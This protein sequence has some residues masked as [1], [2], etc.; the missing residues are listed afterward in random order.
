MTCQLAVI[1]GGTG[2]FAA[3]W[4]ALRKG[5]K[6]TVTEEYDRLGGQLTSQAVPPDEHPWIESCGGTASYRQFRQYVRRYYR[7]WYPLTEEAAARW[8]RLNPGEGCVSAL[9]HEPAVSSAVI[10]ALLRPYISSGQL[11]VL[12]N[13]VPVQV[14]RQGDSIKSVAVKRYSRPAYGPRPLGDKDFRLYTIEAPF[15]IDATETGD[16]LPLAGLEYSIGAESKAQTGEPHAP[17]KADPLNQQAVSWCFVIDY[18]PDRQSVIPKPAQYGFWRGYIPDLKPAWG[19]PL[20]SWQATHPITLEPVVRSFNPLHPKPER[21]PM[22]LW[23]FRRISCAANFKYPSGTSDIVLVNWPQIDY[24]LGQVI[25]VSEEEK[26]RHLEGARQLSLSMLYWM[27]TEAPREDGQKGWPGLGLRPDITQT[28]DG[29]AAAPYIR[30]AR[31]IKGH[32]VVLEQY[33]SLEAR[34]AETGLSEKEVRAFQFADSA[35][36]G[37]YRLDLHPSASGCNYID[38]SALPFQIPLGALIPRDADNLLAGGKNLSVTHITNGCYRLH[39]VEWNVGEA[40]A[41]CAAYCLSNNYAPAKLWKERELLQSF[42]NE[43]R[44][45]GIELSWEGRAIYPL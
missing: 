23:T 20:L 41:L 39:P 27:Q 4:A 35:G 34:M 30:E 1:G 15:F 28:P 2:G 43:L 26:A 11:Q 25:E 21:G 14:S 36:I 6:V 45:F 32:T 38:V 40:A 9:C 8:E 44:E 5:L 12:L 16:L 37:A 42:Q 17:E 29:L 19:S 3:V 24:M 33:V 7:N 31:R 22:D 13:T 18:Q 10:E